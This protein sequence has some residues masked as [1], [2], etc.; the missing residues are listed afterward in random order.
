MWCIYAFFSYIVKFSPQYISYLT[1]CIECHRRNSI[2]WSIQ[3]D[4]NV[5]FYPE[6]FTSTLSDRKCSVEIYLAFD[7]GNDCKTN[8]LCFCFLIHVHQL[9]LHLMEQNG[10]EMYTLH[11]KYAR[12]QRKRRAGMF[13]ISVLY[14]STHC[15]IQS[16]T[17]TQS[18]HLFFA[19]AHIIRV[20]NLLALP[21]YI[22]V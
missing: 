22:N 14:D 7:F 5:S 10:K 8:S 2:D 17:H 13:Y 12:W 19:E 9:V 15:N 16:E 6:F 4:T 1:F 11:K 3:I 18:T 20:A 21:A